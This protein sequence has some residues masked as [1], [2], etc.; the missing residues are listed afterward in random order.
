MNIAMLAE[1]DPEFAEYL[2]KA[3]REKRLQDKKSLKR[4]GTNE[5]VPERAL[6]KP[7]LEAPPAPR[8]VSR[9]EFEDIWCSGCKAGLASFNMFEGRKNFEDRMDELWPKRQGT[10]PYIGNEATARQLLD[11]AWKHGCGV[12]LASFNMH[13]GTDK[14]EARV[15]SLLAQRR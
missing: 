5:E 8:S 11:A 9:R 14:Y 2:L 10:Q 3:L 7:K 12:G 1:K 4:P 15:A 13:P 6:K